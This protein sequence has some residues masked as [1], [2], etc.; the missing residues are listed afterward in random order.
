MGH[1]H[2][3]SAPIW[4]SATS[5]SWSTAPGRRRS[6]WSAARKAAPQRGR[7]APGA[8]GHGGEF[9]PDDLLVADARADA[10]VGAAG[11][12]FLTHDSGVPQQSL[13]DQIRMLHQIRSVTDHTG[14]QDLAFG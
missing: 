1:I 12:V 3:R 7:G 10:A 8:F 13:L 9:G 11:D 2:S 6:C 4:C 14:H 5:W